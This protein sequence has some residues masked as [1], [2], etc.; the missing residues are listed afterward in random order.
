M[1]LYNYFRSSASYRV[2]IRWRAR[3]MPMKWNSW[4]PSAKQG[5]TFLESAQDYI[6]GYA[7]G[8]DMTRRDLQL[9]GR[10]RGRPW[11][12]ARGLTSPRRSVRFIR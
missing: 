2:R 5:R 7:V 11:D 3:P 8:L 1:K 4:W 9:A 6:F 10:D 12:P